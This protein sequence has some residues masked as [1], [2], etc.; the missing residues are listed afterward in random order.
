MAKDLLEAEVTA[1]TRSTFS[2][3][4]RPASDVEGSHTELTL[5]MDY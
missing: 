5:L 1:R 3:L 2:L 4:A